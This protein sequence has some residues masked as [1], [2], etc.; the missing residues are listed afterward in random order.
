MPAT[1]DVIDSYKTTQ[2]LSQQQVVDVQ[3]ITIST[4]P[5]GITLSY[6][7]PLKIWKEGPPYDVLDG[8]AVEL[9]NLVTNSHVVAGQ[10][11]A[12]LDANGLLADYVDLIVQYNQ[13]NSNLPP[14]QGTASIPVGIIELQATD[15]EFF[16]PGHIMTPGQ[17]VGVEYER[18][19]A[20]SKG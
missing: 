15:P 14:L 3:Y 20:L 16:G 17:R 7:M 4:V 19:V 6:A 1:Y 2:S 13:P 11:V 8:M 9:E 18:L 12:D 10:A 5:T